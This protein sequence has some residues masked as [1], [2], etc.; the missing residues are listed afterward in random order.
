M[1]TEKYKI[2]IVDD[3][4][5]IAEIL[6]FNLKNE[7]FLVET[8]NSAEEALI[9]P[10]KEYDLLLLD[11]MM[12]G[13]S[14]YKLA[15]Q[16]RTENFTVPIIFITAK[17]TENDLLTGFSVGGDD[18]ITKP[19]SIKELIARVKA[20]LKR[21]DAFDNNQEAKVLKFENLKIDFELKEVLIN[22]ERI[23]LTKTEFEI[24]TLLVSKSNQLFS[25]QRLINL[26]WSET[27]YITERTV[28]V[29]IARLRKKMK[30]Y[31]SNIQNRPGYG[32]FFNAEKLCD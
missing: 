1:Q 16:L 28:D 27:P 30:N 20:L 8:V 4:Q 12:G 25:R 26:L 15:A 21:K 3:D 23:H 24:L 6:A 18:Y 7:N 2:L 14:G 17:D 13:M 11:V 5:H 10:L 32:Y 22:N 19:F 9:K 31:A 29:H